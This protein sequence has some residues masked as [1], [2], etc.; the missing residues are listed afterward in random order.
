MWLF[1][2]ESALP[3]AFCS[4]CALCALSARCTDAMLLSDSVRC[5]ARRAALRLLFPPPTVFPLPSAFAPPPWPV[6][7]LASWGVTRA[8]AG[9]KQGREEGTVRSTGKGVP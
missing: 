2:L 6:S 9:S 3:V 1:L 4:A 7:D 5:N 8:A